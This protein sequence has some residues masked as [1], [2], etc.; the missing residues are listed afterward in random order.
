MRRVY[1]GLPT[2]SA[3]TTLL[4]HTEVPGLPGGGASGGPALPEGAVPGDLGLMGR[5]DP[6]GPV[7][8]R[9]AD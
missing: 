1:G 4:V 8:L 3:G 2:I 6:G 9:V 5:A 7:L